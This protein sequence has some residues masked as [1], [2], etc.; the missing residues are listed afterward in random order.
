MTR[1]IFILAAAA[2]AA[3][4]VA[5]PAAAGGGLLQWQS[6]GGIQPCVAPGDAHLIE[7]FHLSGL[8]ANMGIVQASANDRFR[9]VLEGNVYDTDQPEPDLVGRLPA[10]VV[11]IEPLG[12]ES[13]RAGNAVE[14]VGIDWGP[15]L[16]DGRV[17]KGLLDAGHTL[18]VDVTVSLVLVDG[19]GQTQLLDQTTAQTTIA[20]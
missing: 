16:D 4:A 12:E 9:L 19:D 18:R 11:V 17:W 1:L 13:L 10:V 20:P 14:L 15:P 8:S 5:L 3:L 2:L 7:G 6:A